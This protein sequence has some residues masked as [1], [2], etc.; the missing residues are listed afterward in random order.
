MQISDAYGGKIRMLTM[1][2]EFTRKCFTVRYARKIGSIQVIE[3][4]ANSMFTHGI[5]QYIRSDN[6]PEFI[7]IELRNWLSCIGVKTADTEPSSPWENDFCES[8]NGASRDNLLDG[9]SST[10]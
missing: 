3:Q 10:V 5:S 9:E 4:F 2:D 7:A 6:D 1:N 8:L